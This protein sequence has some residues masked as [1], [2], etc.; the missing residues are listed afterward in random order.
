MDVCRALSFMHGQRLVH[1]DLKP[2]NVFLSK[3]GVAK[4]GDFG[5]T[6]ASDFSRIT[7]HG[8][9]VGTVAYMPPEQALGG[10]ITPQSDLYAPGAMLYEMITGSPPFAGDDPTVVISQHIN[11]PPVA[12]SWHTED[13]P[14]QLERLVLSL[15]EKD[16][17]KRPDSADAV[18]SALAGIDPSQK[19]RSHTDSNVLDRLARGVFVGREKE[20]EK[21]RSAFDDAFAG[22][23]SVV[24]LVGEPGIGKTRTAQEVET[25]AR[26]RG[27]EVLWG[28]T[29]ES[30]GAP[31]YLPWIQVG[32]TWGSRNDRA[33]LRPK[34]GGAAAHLTRLFPELEQDGYPPAPDVTDPNIAQFQLFDA[35]TTFVRTIADDSP[36]V[37]MLDD[38]HWADRPTLNLLQHMARE[39][40]SMR[41]LVVATYRDTELNRT[42]PL[43]ET[44]AVLNREGAFERISLRG[45]SQA[46]VTKYVAA[47][48]QTEPQADLVRRIYEET[49][50]NP[51]F[52]SEMVNLMT[53]EGTLDRETLTDVRIP[54]G[55]REALGR[56]LDRLT[57][58]ANELLKVAAVIGRD[59][60][61]E[62]LGLVM[63]HD[64]DTRCCYWSKKAWTAASSRR[65][66]ARKVPIHPRT[67]AGNAA[68][69][70]VH[71]PPRP[72]PWPNRGGP[73]GTVRCPCRESGGGPGEALR[74]KR[75]PQYG[76]CREGASIFSSGRRRRIGTAGVGRGFGS[77]R[78]RARAG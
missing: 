70:A 30:P 15:L 40:P 54:E 67:H 64:A 34:L 74:R 35:Y 75:R 46:E 51:F 42:H 59:F 44:L 36:T 8:M 41:V 73:G 60:A 19:S 6:I 13:C 45:L 14:P 61:Y 43:S 55:V 66:T 68:R 56:R 50:G 11:T 63:D 62:T 47:V 2:A 4:V 20:L 5:L 76:A 27:A 38:L 52:L 78:T 21:L 10:D 57:E 69:R 7:Q 25:Y 17:N 37:V 33:A 77:F 16:Q 18:L 65:R 12:P 29:H 22:R 3:E 32:V 48:L 9:M 23:G 53:E 39:L 49:E 31:P 58:E 24:M 26:M 71:H 1:R 72:P 28:R